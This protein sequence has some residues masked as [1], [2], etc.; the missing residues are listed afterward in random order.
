MVLQNLDEERRRILLHLVRE[1]SAT[2]FYAT[3]ARLR[4]ASNIAYE[5]EWGNCLQSW[6]III[7]SLASLR[8]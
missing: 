2:Y 4:Y 7:V 8:N 3:M 6:P 1:E 5:A